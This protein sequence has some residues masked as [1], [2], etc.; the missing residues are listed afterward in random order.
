[1]RPFEMVE[2][3]IGPVDAGPLMC[4]D[5]TTFNSW[6]NSGSRPGD[7]VAVLSIGGL[8]QLGVQFASKMGF[9]TIVARV[10][11]STA[12]PEILPRH[13]SSSVARR[14][15]WRPPPA[16]SDGRDHRRPLVGC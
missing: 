4:A 3:E 14:L 5:I 2:R 11:T 13:C 9:R 15:S 6:R 7:T 12:R 16:R 8:G 10:T 1:G